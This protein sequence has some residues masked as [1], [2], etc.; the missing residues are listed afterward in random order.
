MY[1]PS[2][3]IVELPRT[4]FVTV[5]PFNCHEH[6]HCEVYGLFEVPLSLRTSFDVRAPPDGGKP[7]SNSLVTRPERVAAATAATRVLTPSFR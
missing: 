5:L 2:S 7:H 6:R 4:A 1:L 3:C